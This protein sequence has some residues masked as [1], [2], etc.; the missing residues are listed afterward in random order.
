[1]VGELHEPSSVCEL[2]GVGSP[3]TLD[4]HTLVSYMELHHPIL[5]ATPSPHFISH[6]QRNTAPPPRN[7][8]PG[9][10]TFHFERPI[11][12]SVLRQTGSA[13]PTVHVLG[14][15]RRPVS[16]WPTRIFDT[17]L[18]CGMTV[19]VSCPDPLHRSCGWITSP[20]RGGDVVQS[21]VSALFFLF[22]TS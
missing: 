7:F 13:R 1:M 18:P 17:L 11:V 20:L 9:Q 3:A 8:R 21:R 4:D 10:S 16:Q 12:E 14:C 19:L 15:A 6:A 2:P 5:L 22:F